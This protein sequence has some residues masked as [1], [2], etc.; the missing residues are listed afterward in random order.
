MEINRL[1]KD[2]LEYELNVRGITDISSV[3]EMRKCLRR[4]LKLEKNGTV[5]IRPISPANIQTELGMIVN[6]MTEIKTLIETFE[7]AKLDSDYRKIDTKLCHLLGRTE[8]IQ[9]EEPEV[10]KE[11]SHILK[12]ILCAMEELE[13]QSTPMLP[14]PDNREDEVSD[15]AYRPGS[16]L[17]P[18]PLPT[19]NDSDDLT[20][21]LVNQFNSL[22]R[23]KTP[24]GTKGK[25]MNPVTERANNSIQ[26]VHRT[27]VPVSQWNIKFTGDGQG[28]SVNAF[29]ERVEDLCDARHVPREDLWLS[30]IDLFQDSALI[31]FRAI[32]NRV[33]SWRELITLLRDEFL[34]F[35]YEEDLLNEIKSRT[36]GEEERFGIYVATMENLFRRLPTPMPEREKLRLLIRNIAPFYSD[37]LSLQDISSVDE[38]L[39]L[40]R[41]L[42]QSRWRMDRFRPPT[43]N[44]YL[45]EP[46]LAYKGHRPRKYNTHADSAA[47]IPVDNGTK[48]QGTEV[49]GLSSLCWNC[50]K[51]GHSFRSCPKPR[52]GRFCY[53]CGNPNVVRYRCVRCNKPGNEMGGHQ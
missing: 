36:Q 37:R 47:P 17:G 24:V 3:E 27:Q 4:V 49:T 14:V 43:A 53:G 34:P 12:E 33:H 39:C 52:G 18:Q 29:I 50:A 22:L 16:N 41:K 1:A 2:E 5:M 9:S 13:E 7:G 23:D 8:R 30:A 26:H 28:L 51:E 35:D 45:L 38:L 21:K 10:M 31:W 25:V 32:R 6:K 19:D 15:K 42:E 48:L 11:R 44:R 40:G 46:D 20:D